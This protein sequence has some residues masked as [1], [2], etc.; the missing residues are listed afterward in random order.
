MVSVALL[1]EWRLSSWVDFAKTGR[2]K[3]GREDIC[4]IMN[5]KQVFRG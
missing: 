3:Q 1:G 2:Q 5:F 4:Y